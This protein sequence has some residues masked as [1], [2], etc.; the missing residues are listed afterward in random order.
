MRRYI[1]ITLVQSERDS[2]KP[3]NVMLRITW[4]FRR[5]DLICLYARDNTV[6][7][8]KRNLSSEIFQYDHEQ[9][10]FLTVFTIVNISNL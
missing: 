6:Q 2:Q 4:P 3:S 10:E 7:R 1:I 8:N 5:S 9:R